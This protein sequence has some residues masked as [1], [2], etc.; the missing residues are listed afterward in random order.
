MTKLNIIKIITL[1][2]LHDAILNKWFWLYLAIFLILSLGMAR[3][4]F[5]GIGNYG[6]TGFGRTA[7]SLV[8]ISMLIVPL[9]GLT[10]GALSISGEREKGTLLYLLSHPVTEGEIL[11]GKFIGLSIALITALTIGFGITGLIIGFRGGTTNIVGFL[12]L[13]GIA[14]LFAL[15][16]LSIGILVS[17]VSSKGNTSIGISVF[18]WLFMVFISD[19]GLLG[20]SLILKLNQITLIFLSL[21]NPSQVFKIASIWAI[22]GGV[23]ILGPAGVYIMREYGN[24]FV[25]LLLTFLILWVIVPLLTSYFLLKKKGALT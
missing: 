3:F 12:S 16:S 15:S 9:M 19:L 5:T 4:G 25:W 7:A 17:S 11:F 18:I 24:L 13:T 21:V 2:E 23:D 22:R 6:V 10:L 14:L 20:I 8:N 1:K